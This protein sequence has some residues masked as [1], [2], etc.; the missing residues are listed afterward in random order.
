LDRG[1]DD[2][3][4]ALNPGDAGYHEYIENIARLALAASTQALA[5]LLELEQSVGIKP[6]TSRSTNKVTGIESRLDW[7]EKDDGRL[8]SDFLERFGLKY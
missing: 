8:V 2:Q 7:L 1:R 3:K 4:E 5:K 6:K